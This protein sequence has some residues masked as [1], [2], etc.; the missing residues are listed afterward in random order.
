[1]IIKSKTKKTNVDIKETI[2]WY[3]IIDIYSIIDLI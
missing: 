3:I 1:M 2:S